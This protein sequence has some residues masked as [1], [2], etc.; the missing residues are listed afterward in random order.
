MKSFFHRALFACLTLLSTSA[1]A[2]DGYR[3][4]PINNVRQEHS[5]WCWAGVSA[6]VLN[7]YG[8]RPSQC[9]IVNWAFNINYACGNSNFYWNS[10]ANRPNG[11]YGGY[12]D[13]Q[14]ILRSWNVYSYGNNYA[15]NWSAVVN[16]V[17]NNRP[18]VM[19]Y[20]WTNGGGHFI[21]GYGYN[22]TSGTRYMAYMNP[23]PGEGYT[24]VN[25]NWAVSASDHR[26][27]HTLRMY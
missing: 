20:G 24:W 18:F 16:E 13:I 3:Y 17:R 6:S 10:Y 22:D 15:L 11:I 5:N 19:R 1:F 12:G 27:T 2:G 21:V 9:G 25:Y 4:L 7:W 23:W 14:A 8:H 26:W